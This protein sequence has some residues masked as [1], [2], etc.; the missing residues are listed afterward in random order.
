MGLLLQD[1]VGALQLT[2][3]YKQPPSA[4][5]QKEIMTWCVDTYGDPRSGGPRCGIWCP[6]SNWV[7]CDYEWLP[8]GGGCYN[9][10][11]ADFKAQILGM[12]PDS[13]ES[14]LEDFIKYGK[15]CTLYYA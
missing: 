5:Y 15:S 3:E 4:V 7:V 11:S 6:I 13:P 10:A 1:A 8:Q 2:E 9:P 12:N 14:Q